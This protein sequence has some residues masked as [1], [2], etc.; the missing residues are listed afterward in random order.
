MPERFNAAHRLDQIL[1]EAQALP[2]NVSTVEAWTQVFRIT[3]PDPPSAAVEAAR[4]VGLLREQTNEV[5]RDMRNTAV[6]QQRYEGAFTDVLNALE[7]QNLSAQWGNFQQYLRPEV[8]DAIS[9]CADILPTEEDA[10]DSEDLTRFQDEVGQFEDRIAGSD[11]PDYVKSLVLQQVSIIEQ[12]IRE[13]P[14]TGAR[15]FG[16]GYVNSFVN[17]A[18]NIDC[19]DDMSSFTWRDGRQ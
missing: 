16:R 8:L 17:A 19:R 6:R 15:A 12:A 14:I 11:L 9:W 18:E 1:R 3:G 2:Q 7:V 10:I 5:H 4:M 13:Y